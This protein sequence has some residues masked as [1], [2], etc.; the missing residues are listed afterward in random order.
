MGEIDLD[1]FDPLIKNNRT[2]LRVYAVCL[3]L[4]FVFVNILVLHNVLIAM[5][6]DTYVMMT[7]V[8]RGIYNYNVIGAAPSFKPDK[9][10]GGLIILNLPFLSIISFLLIPF[11]VCIKDNVKL[12]KINN[13]VYLFFYSLLSLPLSALFLALNLIMMPLAYV[14]ICAHKVSLV[15]HKAIPI[16]TCVLYILLGPFFSLISQ[17]TDLVAHLRVSFSRDKK[18]TN[19]EMHCISKSDFNLFYKII[20]E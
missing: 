12:E 19:D 11:Y 18:T 13:L 20:K 9:K 16:W 1:I 6:A 7:S 14:K 5:M 10:Y 8:R 15:R 2:S 17:L 4:S 3:V